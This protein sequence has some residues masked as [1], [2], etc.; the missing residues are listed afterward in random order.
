MRSFT[1]ALRH[2]LALWVLLFSVF[3]YHF[4]KIGKGWWWDAPFF[5]EHV[6][7]LSLGDIGRYFN[8]AWGWY[9]RPLFLTY[10]G[11]LRRLFGDNSAPFV[12]ASLLWH[13]L[14]I[15][16]VVLLARRLGMK[17]PIIAGALFAVISAQNET[18]GWI[19]ATS[20]IMAT[21]CI[22]G[23][24][25]L[26]SGSTPQ[27]GSRAYVAALILFTVGL[28]C[29]E[30]SLLIPVILLVLEMGEN[31]V[32]KT[33]E[34]L[35]RYLPFVIIGA[36]YI[37]LS[38]VAHGHSKMF[39][40][41]V[42]P[43]LDILLDPVNG[44]FGGIFSMWG[45]A[46][47]LFCLCVVAWRSWNSSLPKLFFAYA[48]LLSIP[49]PLMLGT[50]ANV[51]RFWYAASCMGALFLLSLYESFTESEKAGQAV[52]VVAGMSYLLYLPFQEILAQ[53]DLALYSG[54]LRLP[55]L[56]AVAYYSIRRGARFWQSVVAGLFVAIFPLFTGPLFALLSALQVKSTASAAPQ[57]RSELPAIS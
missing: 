44:S 14:A 5:L 25:M 28:G 31:K 17:W 4:Q 16:L 35:L 52:L 32:E 27:L 42:K 36:G 34:S 39:H 53:S 23:C 1:R 37:Y 57:L 56:A 8:P 2:P 47:S 6:P 26:W 3:A 18:V 12:V 29:K 24:L 21:C 11:L 40:Q 15:Y 13:L 55:L 33:R 7:A 22:L 51:G 49:I 54:P 38:L 9:Y 41:N 20:T 43:Q 10:F 50:Y 19:A 46:S 30:E 48:L 45:A